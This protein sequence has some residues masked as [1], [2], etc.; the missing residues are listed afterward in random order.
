MHKGL[1]VVVAALDFG[2]ETLRD[3]IRVR[4]VEV[5]VLT[6]QLEPTLLVEMGAVDYLVQP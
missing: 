5:P 2:A 1:A 4:V 6:V 3:K